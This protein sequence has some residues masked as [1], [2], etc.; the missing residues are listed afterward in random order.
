MAAQKFHLGWFLQG[1]SVQ[2][3]N[4][5]WTG[6][7][8]H[9]W[10][11]VELFCD[12]AR[13]LERACFDYVLI[14]DSSYVGESYGE[15]MDIYLAKALSTPR[16]DP[17][18]TGALMTQ[19]TSR[20]G[21]VPTI[22]TYQM[23]PYQLARTM[24][25]LDQVSRGRIGWNMVTGSSD[26][27]A[28]NFGLPGMPPHD[29]RYDMADEYMEAVNGLWGSWDPDAI[30][31]DRASGVLADGSKVRH[32]DFEGKYYKTHGPLNSGP[33][34]QGRPVIA[35]AGGSERGREFGA[36][37]ADTIV[38]GVRTV[39]AMIDYR[40][41]VRSRMEKAGRKPDDCKILFLV[42]PVLGDTM[43]DAKA[44]KA[45]QIQ[46]IK[47][48]L[49]ERLAVFGKVTNINFAALDWDAP[50]GELTTNGHQQDLAQFL[51][52]AGPTTTLREAAEAYFTRQSA[53]IDLVG[54]PAEVAEMM[55]DIMEQVGGDGFLITLPDTSRK[56]V[57]EIAD[58]LVP[59]LQKRGLTRSS[60]TY[61]KFRDN[62]LEF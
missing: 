49:E 14:E 10:Q 35:Q 53:A 43:D 2:A 22:G 4:E 20:I 19:A 45:R 33:L 59:E 62:M 47:D 37:H 12:I 5:P 60:Y 28:R 11:D 29:E 55:D 7:I 15:S 34:P 61:E 13:A 57:A 48:R 51:A 38:A 18:V 50:V 26:P 27:A 1:S 32:V 58:G 25:T 6:N 9:E 39:E 3:W 41:D 16:Q 30:V 24:G 40:N 21:I 52:S 46:S 23:H 36:L 54:S 56:S 42:S 44:R 8:D 17:I 31:A